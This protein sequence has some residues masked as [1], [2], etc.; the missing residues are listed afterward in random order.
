M[1]NE[2]QNDDNP[3]PYDSHCYIG[4]IFFPMVTGWSPSYLTKVPIHL[5]LETEQE[6]SSRHDDLHLAPHHPGPGHQ[7]QETP[8]FPGALSDFQTSL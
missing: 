3:A 2:T 1:H 5:F 7:G 4:G 6:L 8:A